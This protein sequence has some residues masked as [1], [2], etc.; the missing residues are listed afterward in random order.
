MDHEKLVKI[1][2]R[3]SKHSAINSRAMAGAASL[4]DT[5]DAPSLYVLI[6]HSLVS[7]QSQTPTSKTSLAGH[8][9]P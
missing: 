5:A 6:L 7:V 4:D 9:R 2:S 1:N 8:D 3:S